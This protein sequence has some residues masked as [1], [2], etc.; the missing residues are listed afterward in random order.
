MPTSRGLAAYR[1]MLTAEQDSEL[2]SKEFLGK[3]LQ[4]LDM[5]MRLQLEAIMWVDK[6]MLSSPQSNAVATLIA[7]TFNHHRAALRLLLWGYYGE[8]VVLQRSA[9]EA[10]TLALYLHK[11]PEKTTQWLQGRQIPPS[12]VR[13]ALDKEKSLSKLYDVLCDLSH[14]N[15]DITA[16]GI[17]VFP[18]DESMMVFVGPHFNS[19]TLYNLFHAL[20]F[21][22]LSA[23]GIVATVYSDM[24]I[25]KAGWNKRLVSLLRS[26]EKKGLPHDDEWS[27]LSW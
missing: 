25:T 14:P 12:E 10:M 23:V 13:N 8:S 20:L 17:H 16:T 11:F 18:N 6:R 2:L 15:V 4:L 26:L 7:R 3:D 9:F 22:A 24:L 5:A 27:L 19:Q 21:Q 1:N